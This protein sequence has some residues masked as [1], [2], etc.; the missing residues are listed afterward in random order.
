MESNGEAMKIHISADTWNRLQPRGQYVTESRGKIDIKGKGQ[1]LTYFLIEK[2][3]KGN[4]NY[5]SAITPSCNS[6]PKPAV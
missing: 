1:M 3:E 6:M 5:V 2:L 4:A